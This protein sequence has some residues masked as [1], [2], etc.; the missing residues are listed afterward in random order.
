MW[1]TGPPLFRHKKADDEPAR[2]AGGGTPFTKVT[3]RWGEEA[4]TLRC[5]GHVHVHGNDAAW[6]CATPTVYIHIYTY[7]LNHQLLSNGA[8]HI[9]VQCPRPACCY[10]P[11]CATT[12]N[13]HPI[14]RPVV[15]VLAPCAGAAAAQ[16]CCLKLRATWRRLLVSGEYASSACAQRLQAHRQHHA[17]M[18]RASIL[19]PAVVKQQQVLATAA[20][21][22]WQAV[23][24]GG[25][26][27][28]TCI[29]CRGQR[30][31]RCKLA[32][33]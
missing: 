2:G 12:Q 33:C 30:R 18:Q 11:L 31:K 29:I 8:L 14:V 1:L 17:P 9:V 28:A 3:G 24:C 32:G 10:Q 25:V 26:C 23:Q 20:C 15:Y 6:P 7:V 13:S 5:T 21:R 27:L 19:H 16:H 4:Q 22:H